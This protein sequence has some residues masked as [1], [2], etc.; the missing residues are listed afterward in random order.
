MQRQ[1]ATLVLEERAATAQRKPYTSMS[2]SKITAT[3][4][5]YALILMCRGQSHRVC[6]GGR[7]PQRDP[8][9]F[10]FRLRME[11]TGSRQ[12]GTGRQLN[13]LSSF[14]PCER[15]RSSGEGEPSGEGLD[16]EPEACCTARRPSRMRDR[17]AACNYITMT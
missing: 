13:S 4:S 7:K 8:Q 17:T 6:G 11:P 12:I 14:E 5:C 16:Q 1:R 15:K 2:T 3:A 10:R 9:R